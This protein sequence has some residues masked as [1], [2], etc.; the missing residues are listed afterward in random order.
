MD[1]GQ[2]TAD[3]EQRIV[4]AEFSL[5]VFNCQLSTEYLALL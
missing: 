4:F 5:S 2:W 3:N 1:K